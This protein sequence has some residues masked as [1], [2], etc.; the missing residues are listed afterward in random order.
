MS[1]IS[2]IQLEKIGQFTEFPQ[3][4]NVVN[5]SEIT[6]EYIVLFVSNFDLA[7]RQIIRRILSLPTKACTIIK[8]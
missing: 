1:I 8:V 7:T 2:V 3:V 6:K 4:E 5:M